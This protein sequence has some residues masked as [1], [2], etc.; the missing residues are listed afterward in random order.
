VRLRAASETALAA[1]TILVEVVQTGKK[2]RRWVQPYERNKDSDQRVKGH[3]YQV[4]EPR[5]VTP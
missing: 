2:K 4:E 5:G 1:S 3:I